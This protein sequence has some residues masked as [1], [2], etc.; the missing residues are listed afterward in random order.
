MVLFTESCLFWRKNMTLYNGKEGSR[1]AEGFCWVTLRKR[2]KLPIHNFLW[3]LV[4]LLHFGF[5]MA[6]GC[7]KVSLLAKD[8]NNAP[9]HSVH[10]F[11]TFEIGIFSDSSLSTKKWVKSEARKY[12]SRPDSVVLLREGSGY[13]IGW[14][15]GKVSKGGGSFSIR[16]FM[17]QILG[18]L[19]RAFWA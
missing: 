4:A 12:F 19:N 5:G 10:E 11:G 9:Q 1:A 2:G 18:T 3:I 17:L 7:F 14:I 13:Q 6:A 16:K 8:K 15:V